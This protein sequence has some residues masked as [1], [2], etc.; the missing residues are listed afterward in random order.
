MK[1]TGCFFSNNLQKPNFHL[2][3]NL[4][5]NKILI[6]FVVPTCVPAGNESGKIK[7]SSKEDISISKIWREM[8]EGG[9]MN[10]KKEKNRGN[11]V[12]NSLSSPL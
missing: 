11:R 12:G 2:R 10:K 7:I 6:I 3:E 4:N 5:L 8:G 1:T 9:D